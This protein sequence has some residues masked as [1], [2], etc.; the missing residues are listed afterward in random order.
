MVT[1]A[2]KYLLGPAGI[3]FLY[4]RRD[5]IERLEPLSTGWF[6]RVDPFAFSLDRLDWSPSARR[7]E[8]GSPPVPNVYA[9]AAGT[10]AAAD[11]RAGDDRRAGEPPRR[12]LR[13]RRAGARLRR[14]DAGRSRRARAAGRRALDRRGR[15][16]PA[17]SSTAASLPPR[18]APACACRSTPTTT[19]R[20]STRCW[21]PSTRRQPWCA[22]HRATP[23]R[24]VPSERDE[25]FRVLCSRSAARALYA[26]SGPACEWSRRALTANG[27]RLIRRV[28]RTGPEKRKGNMQKPASLFS[29]V[30]FWLIALL[31]V[32]RIVFQVSVTAGGVEIPYLG[33]P[34]PGPVLRRLGGVAL[35]GTAW[36]ASNPRPICVKSVAGFDLCH[37]RL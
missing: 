32:L 3:A 11:G 25:Q 30:L 1:G 28:R 33:Q 35:G 10:R 22:A 5:L 37:P 20:T 17:G 4:V 14:G 21:R 2:L 6:G 18:A 26:N 9:A 29:L 24:N 13:Q 34:L 31:Q 7:F 19:T 23:S 12:A 8:T 36:V 15:D 16:G 27:A